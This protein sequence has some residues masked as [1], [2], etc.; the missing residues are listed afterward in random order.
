M[1][2]Q[3]THREGR[4]W[5]GVWG[6]QSTHPMGP[7]AKPERPALWHWWQKALGSWGQKVAVLKCFPRMR[8]W[9]SWEAVTTGECGQW[10]GE[11]Q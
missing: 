6:Q 2:P 4:Q 1:D 11:G 10:A 8:Q 3:G 7:E 5:L 9:G